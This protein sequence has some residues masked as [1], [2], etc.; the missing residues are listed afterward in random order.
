MKQ[1]YQNIQMK[2]A[3]LMIAIT[4]IACNADK[5]QKKQLLKLTA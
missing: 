4:L 2:G 1:N 3:C 5:S